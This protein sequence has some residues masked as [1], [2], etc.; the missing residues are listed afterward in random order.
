[1]AKTNNVNMFK[2]FDYINR[3]VNWL[4]HIKEIYTHSLLPVLAKLRYLV[5]YLPCN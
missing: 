1:M 4:R 5:L 3:K 2:A